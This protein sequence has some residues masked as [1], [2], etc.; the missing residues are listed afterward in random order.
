MKVDELRGEWQEW[1]QRKVE[2]KA[3]GTWNDADDGTEFSDEISTY[4]SRTLGSKSVGNT[5]YLAAQE[6]HVPTGDSS[7]NEKVSI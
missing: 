4:F 1:E 6:K 7:S 2:E 5:P 3:A